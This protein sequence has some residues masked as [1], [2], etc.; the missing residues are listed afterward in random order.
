M[1]SLNDAHKD[2]LDPKKKTLREVLNG[3]EKDQMVDILTLT[4]GYLNHNNLCKVPVHHA[5]QSW[6]CAK[7]CNPFVKRRICL[8]PQPQVNEI[9]VKA[10]ED[11][12]VNFT[13]VTSTVSMFP[14]TKSPCLNHLDLK[15][16]V[17][18]PLTPYGSQTSDTQTRSRSS[19]LSEELKLAELMLLK[20]RSLRCGTYHSE[21]DRGQYQFVKSYVAGVTKKDQFNKFVAF[22]KTILRKQDILDKNVISGHKAV[23]QHEWKLSQEL[24]KIGDIKGPNFIR[25]RIFSDVFEDICR[26]SPSF[27]IILRE[28]KAEYD[29]YLA[30]ILESQPS[31]QC[32]NFLAQFQ[33]MD[34]RTVRTHHVEEAQQEVSRLE[35][36]A[37]I[38]LGW[39][40]QRRTELENQLEEAKNLV[41]QKETLSKPVT[42]P[43]VAKVLTVQEQVMLLRSKIIRTLKQI[44]SL[45]D[46]LSTMIPIQL[47]KA[48]KTSLKTTKFQDVQRKNA[49]NFS[50]FCLQKFANII[51]R[52]LH[53]N[54][55]DIREQEN[56]W[57]SI[58]TMDLVE[59]QTDTD[60]K[61]PNLCPNDNF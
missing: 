30:S 44:D 47:S 32:K 38:A 16:C 39:N 23:E 57:S 49:L 35:Q 55:V 33:G 51:H 52:V 20:S 4:S 29:G 60:L 8:P 14:A 27:C 24:M 21:H 12:L 25:L 3:F 37:K 41:A 56:L 6:E 9:K 22:E 48:T 46:N 43:Q 13:L 53:K 2:Y 61:S 19:F 50:D 36:K 40:D 59:S 54:G 7:K 42:E 10:M 17:A 5:N 31:D 11:A 34:S 58:K 28:I 18:S 26:D 45:E 1:K 15:S